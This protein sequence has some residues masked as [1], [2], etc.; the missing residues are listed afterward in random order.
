LGIL[1]LLLALIVHLGLAFNALAA[2]HGFGVETHDH[3]SL[4][5]QGG[6]REAPGDA[7]CDHCCHAPAHLLGVLPQ[8]SALPLDRP[9][10]LS[11]GYRRA[12]HSQVQPPPTRPPK[13]SL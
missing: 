4:A 1:V 3:A 6:E 9:G 7:G 12:W 13:Y 5:A 10:V 11:A 8:D 2:V